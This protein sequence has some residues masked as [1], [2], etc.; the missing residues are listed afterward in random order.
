MKVPSAFRPRGRSRSGSPEK[1]GRKV[2][3][4][5]SASLS[6]LPLTGYLT[7]FVGGKK[8]SITHSSLLDPSLTLY[9]KRRLSG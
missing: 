6:V 4:S 8:F 7:T 3:F 1:R 5:T 2:L 9:I